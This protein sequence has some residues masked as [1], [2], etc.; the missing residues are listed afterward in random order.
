[1]SVLSKPEQPGKEKRGGNRLHAF[2]VRL[3]DSEEARFQALAVQLFGVCD[4][5]AKAAVFRALLK[6]G[7]E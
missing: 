4:H 6:R 3:S 7:L 1:M 2:H 5:G